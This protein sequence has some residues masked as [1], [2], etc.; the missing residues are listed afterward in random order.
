MDG[1]VEVYL[2]DER[3]LTILD[4]GSGTGRL[5]PGLADACG[6]PAYGV[7]PSDRMRA[8]AEETAVHPDMTCLRGRAPRRSRCRRHRATRC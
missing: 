1:R 7:E 5:T 8:I 3:P 6:G 2:A 4:L